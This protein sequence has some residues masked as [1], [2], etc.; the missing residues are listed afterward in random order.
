M[1]CLCVG[2]YDNEKMKIQSQEQIDA[3]MSECPPFMDEFHK[4]GKVLL[5]AGT[6]AEAMGLRRVG[7]EV[8]VTD[9]SVG[10]G[11]ETVGCVFILEARDMEDAVRVCRLHP[12]TRIAAG[13]K[14]GFRI[15]ISPVHSFDEGGLTKGASR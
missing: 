2:Y 12:T 13:E 4:S 8:T 3:F 6:D 7:G 11:H 15:G 14:L 5:V 1:K 9:G 10:C